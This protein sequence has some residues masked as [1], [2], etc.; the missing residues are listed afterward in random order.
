MRRATNRAVLAFAG[1]LVV[2]VVMLGVRPAQRPEQPFRGHAYTTAAGEQAVIRLG[3]GSRVVLAPASRLTVETLFGKTT[4]RVQLSGEAYFDVVEASDAPFI[5]HAGR[6]KTEVLGTRFDIK[7]YSDDKVVQVAVTQGKVT[8][9]TLGSSVA[10][11]AGMVA[12]LTDSTATTRRP[13][14]MTEYTSWADGRLVFHGAPVS[15]M[16]QS[17]SRWTGYEFRLVDS[18]LIAQHVT[19]TL[20]VGNRR[21]TLAALKDLLEVT[22]TFDKNIVTL[23]AI[24]AAAVPRARSHER[25]RDS[26]FHQ[27]L[28]K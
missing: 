7:A 20:S 5:V 12:Q 3:D 4:R 18:A 14:D 28:G 21:E 23:R 8:T 2:A 15:V 27:E 24:R 9:G 13:D 10:L 26:L 22:M 25:L 6:T 17:L 19:A 1:A 11:T 16:L